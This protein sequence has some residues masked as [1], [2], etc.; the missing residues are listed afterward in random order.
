MRDAFGIKNPRLNV[1]RRAARFAE[2][3]IEPRIADWPDETIRVSEIA[4]CISDPAYFINSYCHVQDASSARMSAEQLASAEANKGLWVPFRLWPAQYKPLRL[5]HANQYTCCLKARQLGLTWLALGYALWTR[6]FVDGSTVLLFSRR[7]TEATD[8][9]IRMKGM[10]ERLPT[11]MMPSGSFTSGGRLPGNSHTWPGGDGGRV[12]A[13]PCSAGDSYTASLAIVDE[14]DLVPNLDTLLS[15]VKPTIDAGGK[16][17]LISR[18][19]KSK[20]N[21]PFKNVY[22]GG[23]SGQSNVA[24]C[25]LPW[26]ARESRTHEWYEEQRRES[27]ARTL[28]LDHLHEQYPATDDEALAARQLDKRFPEAAMSAAR[29]YREAEDLASGV[30]DWPQASWGVAEYDRKEVELPTGVRIRQEGG[31]ADA[32]PPGE[33]VLD[34][35]SVPCPRIPGLRLYVLPRPQLRVTIG[36]DPAQGNPGSNDSTLFAVDDRTGEEVASLRGKFAPKVLARYAAE[37]CDWF[38]APPGADCRVMVER[39]NHGHAFLQWWESNRREEDYKA[40]LLCGPDGKVGWGQTGSTKETMYH[41]ASQRVSDGKT[42]IHSRDTY[43][44]VLS[45]EASTLD[46]PEGDMDDLAVAW[47]LALAGADLRSPSGWR[48]REL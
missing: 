2:E 9:L 22:R 5:M 13:F 35:K 27:L 28:T 34:Q 1:A 31:A 15:S 19:D 21:S 47:G 20:P 8:L 24:T 11:W 7:D 23:R 6:L 38:S 36:C 46:A 3:V 17:V 37:L 32:K 30:G 29:V 26:Y 12:M 44:Q 39:N 33:L 41:R 42:I 14:A 45:V 48:M 10:F 4:K 16:L 25:F 40:R 43:D 18:V